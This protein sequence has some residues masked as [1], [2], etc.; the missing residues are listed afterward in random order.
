[1]VVGSVRLTGEKGERERN[2]PAR[3]L[4]LRAR[5]RREEGQHEDGDGACQHHLNCNLAQKEEDVQDAATDEVDMAGAHQH[6]QLDL[7]VVVVAPL[8]QAD[9]GDA[10][11][12][13]ALTEVDRWFLPPSCFSDF[14]FSW[15]R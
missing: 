3:D 5:Q 2:L 4:C 15:G 7:L 14:T 13:E 10:T 12:I 11:D 1:M 8:E 6:H 9:F